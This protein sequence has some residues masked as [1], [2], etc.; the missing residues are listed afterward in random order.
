MP[1]T[2]KLL[3]STTA[4]A[5]P[6]SLAS[7]VIA[8]NESDGRIFYRNGAGTVSTFSSIAPFATTASFPATGSSRVLYLASDSSRLY[9]WSGVYVEIGVAGGSGGGGSTTD[10]SL[11]T[12]GTLAT[13]RLGSG[14]A[15]S[16]NYLRGDQTWSA[17][18]YEY[19]T[20]SDFPAVGASAAVFVS[21]DDGRIFRW[22]GSQYVET[23]STPT[24]V[25]ANDPT[26][27]LTLLH[28]FLLGGM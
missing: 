10:A 14:T 28:P 18:V 2:I 17:V 11:L 1:N 16:T 20:T 7:G 26:A 6:S 5:S 12:S 24:T 21:T 25:S 22:T 4:G 3:R 9:Q 15:S 19:A 8:I 23:G 27:G 13:A